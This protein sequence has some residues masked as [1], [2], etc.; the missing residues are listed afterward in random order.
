M[1]WRLDYQLAEQIW[2]DAVLRVRGIC[3]RLL[4]DQPGSESDW[5]IRLAS[6]QKRVYESPFAAL[7][8]FRERQRMI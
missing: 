7:A 6:S 2:V 5:R 8:R 3:A 1:D 4:V